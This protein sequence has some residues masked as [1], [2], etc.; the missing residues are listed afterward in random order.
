M[1]LMGIVQAALFAPFHETSHYT[2]FRSRRANAVVGWIA[3][4]PALHNWHFYQRFHLAHHK[5]TQD[6]ALDPE[7]YPG[8][9]TTLAGYLLRVT[10]FSLEGPVRG[11]DARLARRNVGLRRLPASGDGAARDRLGAGLLRR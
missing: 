10:G 2:A 4:L 6:P 9:P 11:L 7:A 5:H 3:G 1:L 8:P